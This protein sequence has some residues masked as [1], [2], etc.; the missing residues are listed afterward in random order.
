MRE[1]MC[2]PLPYNKECISGIWCRE[3]GLECEHL[4]VI[5]G[6]Q[7]VRCYYENKCYESNCLKFTFH[8]DYAITN[9][10]MPDMVSNLLTP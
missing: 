8:S 5:Q 1:F 3:N 10:K 2:I 9:S 6:L 7:Q 4:Q